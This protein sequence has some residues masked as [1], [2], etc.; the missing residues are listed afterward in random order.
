M[1]DWER[2]LN[3]RLIKHF[4]K[5]VV[6][7]PVDAEPAVPLSCSLCDTLMRSCDDEEACLEFGCCHFCAM[8]WAHPRRQLWKEGWRPSRDQV[9]EAVS[10]R[11]PHRLILVTD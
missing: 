5:F 10:L 3:D 9:E 1:S 11:P 7:K 6:I 4:D 2:Y 8:T